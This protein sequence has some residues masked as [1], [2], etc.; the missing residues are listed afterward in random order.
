MAK[1]EILVGIDD[2]Y[3]NKMA[4]IAKQC[5]AAGMIVSQQMRGVSMISGSIEKANIGKIERIAGV[6]YVEES[7]TL[8]IDANS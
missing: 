5:Q 4:D 3:T 7:Q 6:A 2:A 1:V 8:S